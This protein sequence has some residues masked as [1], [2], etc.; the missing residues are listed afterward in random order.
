MLSYLFIKSHS[1]SKIDSLELNCLLF[2]IFQ[3]V[4]NILKWR[5][6]SS[7]KIRTVSP[8]SGCVVTL[9]MHQTNKFT[10]KLFSNH[11]EKIKSNY[12]AEPGF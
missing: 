2:K 12:I 7:P 3:K 8:K 6:P 9:Y 1:F 10:V 4:I 5:D 11:F